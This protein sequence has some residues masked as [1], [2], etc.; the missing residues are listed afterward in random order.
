MVDKNSLVSASESCRRFRA[1]CWASPAA[2]KG[3]SGAA[4]PGE[5]YFSSLGA[6]TQ[7]PIIYRL[8]LMKL[9]Y[10]K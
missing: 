9:S 8:C 6:E 7:V 3:W 1:M 2:S 4:R 10:R 5:P